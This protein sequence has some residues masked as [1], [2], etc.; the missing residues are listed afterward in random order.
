MFTLQNKSSYLEKQTKQ[1]NSGQHFKQLI[2]AVF[3]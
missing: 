3:V 2:K 1:G